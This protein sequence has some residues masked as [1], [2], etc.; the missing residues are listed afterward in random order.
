MLP[1]GPIATC[2]EWIEIYMGTG[3]ILPWRDPVR[4]S[5]TYI[6]VVM[7]QGGVSPIALQIPIQV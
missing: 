3:F 1:Q 6:S 2:P 4:N 5:P 7:E